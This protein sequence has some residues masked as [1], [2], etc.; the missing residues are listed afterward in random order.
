L[1][2]LVSSTNT[3]GHHD[4]TEI[5]LKMVLSTIDQTNQPILLYHNTTNIQ[6]IFI[7]LKTTIRSL[8]RWP[9]V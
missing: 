9:L 7:L 5:L 2:P 1:G 8:P 4:I 3:T 6:W